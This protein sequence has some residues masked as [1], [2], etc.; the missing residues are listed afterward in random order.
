MLRAVQIICS[1]YAVGWGTMLQ[2][3][4][5]RLPLSVSSLDFPIQ[6]H[7]CSW[8]IST[9]KRNEYQEF[10][11][12]KKSCGSLRAT[13]AQPLVSRLSRIHWSLDVSQ[14]GDPPRPVIHSLRTEFLIQSHCYD[15][16]SL[17]MFW[18]GWGQVKTGA[19]ITAANEAL[20]LANERLSKATQ[21]SFRPLL[22][23]F[24]ENKLNRKMLKEK[25][26]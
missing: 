18:Y 24:T 2:A 15:T 9:C 25:K 26:T 16:S 5:S 20:R 14:T 6:P 3:G 19:R 7:C 10:S 1:L 11:W 8:K 17:N 13:T 4:R 21:V 22:T 12:G 23:R